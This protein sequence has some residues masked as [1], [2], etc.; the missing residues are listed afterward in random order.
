MFLYAFYGRAMNPNEAAKISPFRVEIAQADLDDLQARLAN[1]R[2]P[3][4]APGDN[5]DL[6]TPNHYLRE[7]VDHWRTASTGERRKPG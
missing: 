1:T 5:W 3:A 2:L 7:M 6:G 4:E